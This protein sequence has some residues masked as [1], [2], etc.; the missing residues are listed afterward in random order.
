M[1]IPEGI[2]ID[3]YGRFY[4][5]SY[6]ISL[7]LSKT[8]TLDATRLPDS[9]RGTLRFGSVQVQG[10][11]QV[12]TINRIS[13]SQWLTNEMNGTTMITGRKI[14][15][16]DIKLLGSSYA[17]ALF[18]T[19]DRYGENILR[20]FDDLLTDGIDQTIL[21]NS[22]FNDVLRVDT[23]NCPAVVLN[24]LPFKNLLLVNGN[25]EI[26]GQVT[27]RKPIRI[28]QSFSV[29]GNLETE[30]VNGYHLT[31]LIQDTLKTYSSSPQVFQGNAV[32]E[33]GLTVENIETYGQVGGYN[34]SH[35][36]D[37]IILDTDLGTKVIQGSLTFNKAANLDRLD[38]TGTLNG[39][40][41]EV[42]GDGFLLSSGNQVV[43]TPV[44]FQ[45]S[46]KVDNITVT[47]D[48]VSNLNFVRLA[49][50]IVRVDQA[51]YMGSIHF[52]GTVNA[53]QD[54]G[55]DAETG[56]VNGKRIRKYFLLKNGPNRQIITAD[57]TFERGL[58]IDGFLD[59]K[60]LAGI[61]YNQAAK[62]AF[63]LTGYQDNLRIEGNLVLKNEPYFSQSFN[64]YDWT[65]IVKDIWW[66]NEPATLGPIQFSH[67]VLQE[68][69]TLS[70]NLS[71]VDLLKLKNDYLS[72]S[73]DQR[74]SGK[75]TFDNGATFENLNLQIVR[76]NG[77]RINNINLKEFRD[78]VLL[79][80]VDQSI[81]NHMIFDSLDVSE[82]ILEKGA[83]V[84]GLDLN[85]STLTLH[86]DN[87]VSGEKTFE[88]L[89]IGDLR[90]GEGTTLA[91]VN[92]Q[93]WNEYAVRAYGG[94]N[95]SGPVQFEKA[96]FNR[97]V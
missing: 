67:M 60:Y 85:E 34:L 20:G 24:G 62:F 88:N 14:F 6:D 96:T 77:G 35:L 26:Q 11:T 8:L 78:S 91:G 70:G 18:Y 61:D 39:I 92:L 44:R 36:L 93:E 28:T 10:N 2:Y 57:K 46:V 68:G 5:G 94:A 65:E 76:L 97:E 53:G 30:Y 37:N 43:Y 75:F 51:G 80:D 47:N 49:D 73:Y 83:L 59:V 58:R 72:Q 87:Y 86:G 25:Q 41:D 17:K 16:G 4:Q 84:G 82:V 31:T 69:G 42:W 71:G 22:I 23:L 12:R 1:R 89:I 90:L 55:L 66:T 13:P 81:S 9:F 50:E 64:G 45:G 15:T 33:K 29:T 79:D 56:T 3:K 38:Y 19:L 40:A 74:I 54:I 7:L 63:G 32:F 21:R 95:I 48:K 27:F 52:E